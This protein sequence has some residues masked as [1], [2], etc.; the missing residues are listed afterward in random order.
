MFIK[1]EQDVMLGRPKLGCVDQ[2]CHTLTLKMKRSKIKLSAGTKTGKRKRKGMPSIEV[3]DLSHYSVKL[4][5]I[6]HHLML[7]PLRQLPL[8]TDF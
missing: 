1:H 8:A 4:N 5:S 3:I 6:A 7:R 2:A